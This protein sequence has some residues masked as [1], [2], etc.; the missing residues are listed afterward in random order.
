VPVEYA[1]PE[2]FRTLLTT[3]RSADQVHLNPLRGQLIPFASKPPP[4]AMD[5]EYNLDDLFNF[6]EWASQRSSQLPGTVTGSG[7]D[8]SPLPESVAPSTTPNETPRASSQRHCPEQ[9]KLTFIQEAEWDPEQT[10]DGDPLSYLR[11]SIEWKVTLKGKAVSK[12]TEPDVVLAP[13]GN[14]KQRARHFIRQL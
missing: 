11:Y 7:I 9:A 2:T 14:G 8:A 6:Q 5:A 10:Y 4:D 12:D 1:C 3:A 13:A